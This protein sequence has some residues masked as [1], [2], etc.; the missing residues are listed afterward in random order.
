MNWDRVE[1]LREEV[2]EDAFSEVVELFLEETEDVAVRLR[3]APDPK[4]LEDQMH[5]LKGAA[6]NLGFEELAEMCQTGEVA[7]RNGAGAQIDVS[8]ILTCY[9]QSRDTLL[10]GLPN[11]GAVA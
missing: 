1:E 6:L 5:F 2:G 7:A 11:L 3:A 9:E 8:A 4:I 10:K